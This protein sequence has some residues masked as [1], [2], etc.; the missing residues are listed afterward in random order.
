VDVYPIK[1][2]CSS[3]RFAPT[4]FFPLFFFF[5]FIVVLLLFLAEV[6]GVAD[7]GLSA[8]G[9]AKLRSFECPN[10]PARLYKQI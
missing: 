8:A 4:N 2:F 5:V 3:S 6:S 9:N 1:G 10:G 7:G